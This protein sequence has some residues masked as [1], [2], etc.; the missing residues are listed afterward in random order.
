MDY[1]DFTKRKD[2]YDGFL[3]IRRQVLESAKSAKVFNDV[4]ADICTRAI[5]DDC[6]AQDCVAYFFNKGVPDRLMINYNYYLG[7]EI[8]AGANGNEFALEKLE[9]F[10]NPALEQ[11][12]NDTEL[13]TYA[14]QMRNI[15][16]NNALMVISNLLCEGIVD[17]LQ[18]KPKDLID[19][20]SKAVLYSPEINRRYLDALDKCVLDV[21]KFLIS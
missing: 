21:A 11:I 3:K 9:F 1:S 2:A 13:L 12:V 17:Q 4:F 10:L 19:I 15:N 8:L 16:K 14:M 6:V 20:Q 18:L 7:W 5:M